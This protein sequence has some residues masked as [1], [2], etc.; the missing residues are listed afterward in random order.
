MTHD[1]IAGIDEAGYGPKLGPMVVTAARFTGCSGPLT[2]LLA[3][4][5]GPAP[6]GAGDLRLRVDD[7]KAV[8]RGGAGFTD[9][10]KSVLAFWYA[11]AGRLPA[12]LGEMLAGA[13]LPDPGFESCPWYGPAPLSQPL[14]I[15]MTPEMVRS[16]G[17]LL[18]RTMEEAGI[19]FQGF[20]TRVVSEPRF[21]RGVAATDNK[22]GFLAGLVMDLVAGCLESA[23]AGRIGVRVDKLGGRNSYGTMLAERFPSAGTQVIEEGR[24]ISRYRLDREGGG[25]DVRFVRGGDRSHFSVALASMFGKYVREIFMRRFNAFW[26]NFD[27]GLRP[28]AGYPQDARRFLKEFRRAAEAA[29]VEPAALV[30]IR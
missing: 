12:D 5:A 18:V 23:P 19:A 20:L 29:G 26:A 27:P 11:S 17:L 13:G 14:P 15:V 10:E 6:V 30:R 3:P 24:A 7:S 8:Y 21:N 25:A 28:T 16:S 2:G 9:L 22:A 4:A 1:A